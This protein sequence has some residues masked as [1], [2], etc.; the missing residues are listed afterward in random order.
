MSYSPSLLRERL[1][2]LTRDLILI[3]STDDRPDERHRCFQLIRNHLD[4]VPG[5]EIRML[6]KNGYESLLAFH[7][8][9]DKPEVLLC[10]HLDVVHHP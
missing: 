10:G 8:G 3:E 9:I 1:I 4:D 6:E 2:Q 5:I 7:L